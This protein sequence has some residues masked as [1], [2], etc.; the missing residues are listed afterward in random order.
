MPYSAWKSTSCCETLFEVLLWLIQGRGASTVLVE[1]LFVFVPKKITV[2]E[3]FGA[4][5]ST[6]ST[7]P[8]SLKN[9]CS[10]ILASLLN[11]SVKWS[12]SRALHDS[13]RGFVIQRNFLNNVLDLDTEARLAS[14]LAPRGGGFFVLVN[15]KWRRVAEVAVSGQDIALADVIDMGLIGAAKSE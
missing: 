8:I 11:D 5:R 14:R 2:D 6:S 4:I 9:S 3:L 1:S 13:Q 15:R 12:L 10:K 7:R